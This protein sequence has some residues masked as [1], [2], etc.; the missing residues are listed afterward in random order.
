MEKYFFPARIASVTFYVDWEL[1]HVGFYVVG[2]LYSVYMDQHYSLARIVWVDF[3]A[4]DGHYLTL[5]EKHCVLARIVW[6]QNPQDLMHHSLDVDWRHFLAVDPFEK[7]L[8]H[9]N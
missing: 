8:D 2:D 4:D 9:L 1:Y 3:Y 6:V 5:V 7:Q